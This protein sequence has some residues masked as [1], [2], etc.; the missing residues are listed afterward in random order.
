M[1]LS[2]KQCKLRMISVSQFTSVSCFSRAVWLD[3]YCANIRAYFPIFSSFL[4][5]AFHNV[6]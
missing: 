1:T 5:R 4:N 2:L 6:D 3:Q